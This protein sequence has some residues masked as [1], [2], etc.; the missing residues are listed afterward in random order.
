MARTG[1]STENAGAPSASAPGRTS[2][3]SCGVAVI[4]TPRPASRR[5][6]AT[7]NGKAVRQGQGVRDEASGSVELCSTQPVRLERV[8]V[9]RRRQLAQSGAPLLANRPPALAPPTCSLG[10]S[11]DS[12]DRWIAA[13]PLC[14]P[15]TRCRGCMEDAKLMDGW[16]QVRGVAC[17]S[18]DGKELTLGSPTGSQE[19]VRPRERPR[20]L[21]LLLVLPTQLRESTPSSA[22]RSACTSITTLSE[23]SLP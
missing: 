18:L 1:T 12:T 5:G 21:C 2:P 7:G 6:E 14:A 23:S 15:P 13:Q 11:R 22:R 19:H 20:E 17:R 8:S 10:C 16:S 3:P 4:S 9:S